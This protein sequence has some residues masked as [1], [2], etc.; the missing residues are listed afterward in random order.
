[1]VIK[2]KVKVYKYLE[3][4][5]FMKE[6]IIKIK[7]MAKVSTFIQMVKLMKVNGKTI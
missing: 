3:M 1:M 5:V 6:N 7:C 2:D 4:E